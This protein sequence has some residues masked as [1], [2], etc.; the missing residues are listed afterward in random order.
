MTARIGTTTPASP[1][2]PGVPAIVSSRFGVEDGHT[3]DGYR[4]SGSYTGY[5]G[6]RAALAMSPAE[7]MANVKEA[8]LLGRGGAGLRHPDQHRAFLRGI[9][10]DRGDEVGDQVGAA[11]VL[12]LNLGPLGLHLFVLRR[13]GVVTAGAQAQR[14]GDDQKQAAP[15]FEQRHSG[16][17]PSVGRQAA[18]SA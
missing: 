14:H 16:C 12:R 11:L 8:T 17:P 5:D 13:D 3:L 1:T 9:A 18:P 15:G 10:F 2:A 7:V 6:L 4:R